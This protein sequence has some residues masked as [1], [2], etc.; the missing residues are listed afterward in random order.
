M[1]LQIETY[2]TLTRF[3]MQICC[4]GLFLIH[5]VGCSVESD[6]QCK[7]RLKMCQVI[8]KGHHRTDYF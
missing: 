2:H 5:S 4:Y 3:D 8:D 6:T 7:E 1:D